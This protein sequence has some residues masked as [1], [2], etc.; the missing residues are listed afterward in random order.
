MME[1]SARYRDRRNGMFEDQ[2]FQIARF[3]HEGELI[4]AANFTCQF[5]AAHQIDRYIDPV[6]PKVVQ[7]SVLYVL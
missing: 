6:F 4:E 1:A 3:K 7:K 5:N 2:L